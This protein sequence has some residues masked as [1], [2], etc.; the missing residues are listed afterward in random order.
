MIIYQIFCGRQERAN[1]QN[2]K[3]HVF[4]QMETF[5]WNKLKQAGF[6]TVYLLG[7]WD[8]RG[9]VIVT[10]ESGSLLEFKTGRM[11]SIFAV[12][13]HRQPLPQLG[14]ITDLRQLIQIIHLAGLKVLV[15]FIPNQTGTT[16]PWTQ[17]HP[18]FYLRNNQSFVTAF[19]QDVYLLDYNQPE[20]RN[21]MIQTLRWIKQC[22][23]DGVRADMAHLTPASFWREAIS[24][25]KQNEQDFIFLA[26]AYSQS[27]LDWQPLIQLLD[28]GFDLIYHEFLYRNLKMVYEENKPA[29]YLLDHLNYFINQHFNIKLVHYLANHDDAMIEGIC[30]RQPAIGTLL[31]FL[32]GSTLFYNGQLNS[33]NRRLGHHWLD[34]LPYSQSEFKE[35]PAWFRNVVQLKKSLNPQI[36]KL[37]QIDQE[38]IRAEMNLNGLPAQLL[39]NLSPK[40]YLLAND[41]FMNKEGLLHRYAQNE[42]LAPGEAEIFFR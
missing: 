5:D 17:T 2:H 42:M 37:E 9:P 35:I 32:Y 29:D 33:L 39:L 7:V 6:D 30:S 36:E 23:I 1:L 11:P 22:G 34:I 20:L 16:H 4:K 24:Q 31:L 27:V 18:E 13:D 19:S 40:P 41:S 21:E 26:E 28:A 25:L 3:Y 38:I 15:D 10:E 12:S 14:T 8:Y